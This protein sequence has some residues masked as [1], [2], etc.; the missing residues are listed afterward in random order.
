MKYDFQPTRMIPQFEAFLE[1]LAYYLDQGVKC[2]HFHELK[3]QEMFLIFRWFYSKEQLAQL[4]YPIIG[5][6]LNFRALVLEN[7]LKIKNVNE[8]AV[9][10]MMGRSSFDIMF[11]KEFGM[12]AGQWLLKQ[13][14]KHVKFA[15]SMPEAS[16]NDI[17]ATFEFNSATH[18]NRFCKQQFGCT[19]LEMITKLKEERLAKP[20]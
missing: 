17:M 4:F 20:E 6:S 10:S 7:Y 13:K 18:F 15:M 11:K 3:H 14:A 16:I 5:R 1:S 8:L 12:S 9:L 2:E 19:P